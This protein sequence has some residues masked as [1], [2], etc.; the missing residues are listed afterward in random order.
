MVKFLK[1]VF[2]LFLLRKLNKQP[3]NPE[4]AK[5][6][7]LGPFQVIFEHFEQDFNPIGWK[8]VIMAEH[9]FK[10]TWKLYLKPKH[11]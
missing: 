6:C 5:Y 3:T 10:I 8:F 4:N 1:Y 9:I 7:I 2:F 11:G